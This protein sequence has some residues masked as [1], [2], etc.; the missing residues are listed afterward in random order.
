MAPSIIAHATPR[1]LNWIRDSH[2]HVRRVTSVCCG[3]FLLGG[4]G[5]LNARR[6][7][8]HWEDCD[9]LQASFPTARVQP[10][11][12]YVQDGNLWTAAGITAGIDMALALVEEDYGHA[13]ALVVARNLVVFLKRPGGQSQ[14][15]ASLRSQSVEGPLGPL[16]EWIIEHPAED[17]RAERLAE[18]AN[19]SLRN[20]YRVFEAATDTSPADWVEM[21]RVEIAKRHLEQGPDKVGQISR[22]SGFGSYEQMRKVFARRLGVSPTQ[23]RSRFARRTPRDEPT[24]FAPFF[25]SYLQP[26]TEHELP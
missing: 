12:I 26:A 15:S 5:L 8:T 4:A 25:D 6:V 18:R 3:A 14:F 21:V 22:K 2:E 10:D 1:L 9:R 11:S 7:T 17:L 24:T 20:F 23:Y 13:L 19:M 16:L